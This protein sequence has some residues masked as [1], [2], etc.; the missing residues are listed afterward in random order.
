MKA[1]SNILSSGKYN[2]LLFLLVSINIFVVFENIYSMVSKYSLTRVISGA[3][4]YSDNI[5]LNF[6]TSPSAIYITSCL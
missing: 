3:S 2:I 4:V 5:S 1:E 6:A